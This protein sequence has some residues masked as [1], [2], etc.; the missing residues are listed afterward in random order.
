V[1]QGEGPKQPQERRREKTF[2]TVK[3]FNRWQNPNE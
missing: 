3:G 1:Y 2:E